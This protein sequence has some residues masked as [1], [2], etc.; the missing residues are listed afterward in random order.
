MKAP[1]WVKLERIGTTVNAYESADG[2]TWTLVG[3]DTVAMDAAVYI[4]LAVTSHTSLAT[5][6]AVFDNVSVTT[7]F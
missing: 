1:Y 6:T 7:P 2:I 4:G 3:S 5:S